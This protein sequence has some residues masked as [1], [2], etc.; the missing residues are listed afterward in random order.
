MSYTYNKDLSAG[1]LKSLLK[2]VYAKDFFSEILFKN[3]PLLGLIQKE[4]VGGKAFSQPIQFAGARNI[5]ADY[6]VARA[7][8]SQSKSVDFT[9]PTKDLFCSF[10]VGHKEAQAAKAKGA[11]AYVNAMVNEL[12]NALMEF[13]KD[14]SAMLYRAENGARGRIDSISGNVIKLT[15]RLDIVHFG[16][17]HRVEAA[18][19]I[20][21][22]S[23]RTGTALITKINTR[24]GEFTVDDVANITSLAVGDY[25]YGAGDR[26]ER[27]NGIL[28]WIPTYA[29]REAGILDTAFLGV[30]RSIDEVSLAGIAVDGSGMSFE[31]CLQLAE[32]EI[33]I[34]QQTPDTM[35]INP[36]DWRKFC[37]ELS[38]KETIEKGGVKGSGAMAA[39]VGYDVIN[40]AG[41]TSKII[42]DASVPVGHAFLLDMNSWSLKHMGDS[43]I[44]DW[45][46]DSLELIRHGD[47]GVE[48]QM[49]TYANLVCDK[50]KANC[51]ITLPSV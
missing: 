2:I 27:V 11:D 43:V 28:D 33:S 49:F 14:T 6:A 40:V 34:L 46:M 15:E 17:G 22:G 18:A 1:D 8:R 37:V 31:E 32:T 45:T 21:G 7:G 48:G 13:S 4:A 50:P 29:Q 25:L 39:N 10:H 16:I 42:K 26:N 3:Q 35:F 5:S 23:K 44:N 20:S 30:D 41:L 24:K 47:N 9:I 36:S 12:K 51:V 38:S 19:A